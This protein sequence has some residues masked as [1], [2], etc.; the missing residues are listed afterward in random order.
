MTARFFAPAASVAGDRVALPDDEAA[1]L[2]RVLRLG[3]GD[4]VRLFNGRGDEFDGTVLSADRHGVWVAVGGPRA[5]ATE[6][7]VAITLAVAV[8]K[9]DKMDDVVRDA[10]MLGVAAVQ[11][12]VSSRSETS[13]AALAR[14]RRGD[15]WSRIAIASAKQCGRA[16]LPAMHAPCTFESLLTAGR[17]P[18]PVFMFAEPAAFPGGDSLAAAAGTRPPHA[19]ILVGPEGGWT[20]QEIAAGANEWRLVTLRLPTIRADAMPSAATTALLAAWHAL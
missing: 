18:A 3:A 2:T 19:T 9:G 11:P 15:R 16:M 13:L 20:S 14:S 5:A 1:H 7:P 6:L 8:L 17:L 4:A 12:F 10:V